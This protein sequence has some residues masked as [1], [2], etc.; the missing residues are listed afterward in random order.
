MIFQ[1]NPAH[2]LIE[3]SPKGELLFTMTGLFRLAPKIR[4]NLKDLGGAMSFRQFTQR[5]ADARIPLTDLPPHPSPY[6]VLWLFGRGDQSVS[7]YGA[8][9]FVGDIETIID[10]EPGLRP[11]IRSYQLRTYED[12]QMIPRLQIRLEKSAPFKENLDPV[13]LK[14]IFF[15]GLVKWNQDFREVSK[16]FSPDQMDVQ[17]FEA[18]TGPFA[19][20]DSQIKNRYITAPVTAG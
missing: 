16:G 13:R 6:P 2:Y 15:R 17:V 14:D 1:Y 9:V 20:Q 8:K 19:G 4:Y 12:A 7:F 11:A 5:L 3:T 10:R 18:Q